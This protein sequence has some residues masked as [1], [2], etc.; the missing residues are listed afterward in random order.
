MTNI[1]EQRNRSRK[2]TFTLNNN[3]KVETDNI[4]R[5]LSS[6]KIIYS[7]IG[8]EHAP[9]TNTQH[10]QGYISFKNDKSMKNI[11]K[12]F[13]TN[14]VHLEM[15]KG[16]DLQNQKYCSKENV[17]YECGKPQYKGKRND[18]VTL[19]GT[20]KSGKFTAQEL[21]LTY[22]Q[23]TKLIDKILP[24]EETRNT[25]PNVIWIYGP[26][27]SGKSRYAQQI[28]T[29]LEVSHQYR[30]YYKSGNNKWFN[31]YDSHEI[32]II[33]DIR[34]DTLQ[35]N[36]LLQL[37][38][39]HPVQVEIKGSSRQFKSEV[40]IITSSKHPR[41]IYKNKYIDDNNNQLLRRINSLYKIEY[42]TME[43]YE[44]FNVITNI[45]E[46]TKSL[47]HPFKDIVEKYR[48]KPYKR[49]DPIQ[50]LEDGNYKLD[51][52]L[53]SD[54]EDDYDDDTDEDTDLPI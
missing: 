18:L 23:Y 35:F 41:N 45:Y 42:D 15:A 44:N 39:R 54:H 21:Y 5:W 50:V 1:S 6:Q 33:N 30:T 38:D 20:F 28:A 27:G 8:L 25:A 24:Y 48:H 12:G 19:K 13:N 32:T 14:R 49:K 4:I 9:T 29:R 7:I 2:W 16:N 43:L 10:L 40:I 26:S 47:P 36:E 37:T 22:P 53:E 46:N 34:Q 11:K 17:I 3:T 52:Y 31:G 51:K